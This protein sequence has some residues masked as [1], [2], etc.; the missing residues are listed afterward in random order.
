MFF[1][2]V[3]IQRMFRGWL[4]RT[5]LADFRQSVFGHHDVITYSPPEIE[6]TI[7]VPKLRRWSCKSKIDDTSVKPPAS[8]KEA[9]HPQPGFGTHQVEQ[10]ISTVHD[11]IADPKYAQYSERILDEIDR[12]FTLPADVTKV[13]D[14][15]RCNLRSMNLA[16]V[17]CSGSGGPW[18]GRSLGG[19]WGFSCPSCFGFCS[20]GSAVSRG[21]ALAVTWPGVGPLWALGPGPWVLGPAFLSL[22][23]FCSFCAKG[24]CATMRFMT[25]AKSGVE[26]LPT[27]V[28][29]SCL[30]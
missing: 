24:A 17:G 21:L 8:S 2:A 23:R 29:F 12:L 22:F 14:C 5:H 18:A 6:Q 26:A 20:L 9:S 19:A 25:C 1:H 30:L 15:V 13:D 7:K 11:M 3:V 28:L 27:P 16:A 10:L 4:V